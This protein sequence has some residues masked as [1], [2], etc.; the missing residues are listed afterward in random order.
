MASL[1]CVTTAYLRFL[2]NHGRLE[3]RA[4]QL[5][6]PFY[7]VL[8]AKKSIWPKNPHLDKMGNRKTSGDLIGKACRYFWPSPSRFRLIVLGLVLPWGAALVELPGACFTVP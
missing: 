1:A 4:R 6:T 2:Q 8:R 7:T 5:S 3:E